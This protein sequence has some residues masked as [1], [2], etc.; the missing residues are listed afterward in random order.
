MTITNGV[1]TASITLYDAQT[2]TLTATPGACRDLR[3]LHRA[4][5]LGGD[6]HRAYADDTDGGT[7]FNETLTALDAYGNTATGYTGAQAVVFSGP[8]NSPNGHAPTYPASVT[9]TSG[10]GTASITLFDAQSTTLTATQGSRHRDSSGSFTVNNTGTATAFTVSNPGTQTAGTAF[11][12]GSPPSTRTQHGDRLRRIE[13][14]H[15]HRPGELAERSH[16]DLPGDGDL[17]Q[18]NSLDVDHPVR[19]PEHDAHGHPGCHR[20][21]VDELHRQQHRDD[22]GVHRLQ[23]RHADRRHGLH[24]H[25]HRHRHVRQHHDELR[26]DQVG[27]VH[28]PGE[29]PEQHRADVPGDG[30]LH[31]RRGHTVRHTGRRSVDD[32]NGHPGDDRR[33]LDELHRAG[34]LGG[35]HRHRLWEQPVDTAPQRLREPLVV[36]VTD[37]DGNAVSGATVTFTAPGFGASV[38]FASTGTNSEVDATNTSGQATSSTMTANNTRGTGYTI[39]ATVG[40]HT[41]NFSETNT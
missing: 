34:R 14:G 6:V 27:D 12:V 36:K 17:H 35:E 23:P 16:A 40:T 13:V 26:G 41:V 30:D 38:A 5:R 37:T 28:G 20:G 15:V 19:R 22:D 39:S 21:H 2:T 7:A 8:S 11:S 24:G 10:V 18:R 9:F 3:Q 25:H 29:L 32:H 4:G 33:H 1:G 31:E